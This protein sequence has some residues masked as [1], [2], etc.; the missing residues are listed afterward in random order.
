[1]NK[2]TITLFSVFIAVMCIA[3]RTVTLIY[4]T[5]SATGFFISKLSTLGILISVA[6]FVFALIASFFAFTVSSSELK[7]LEISKTNGIISIL[8]GVS[9]ILYCFG[10]GIHDTVFLW[11]R[12]LETVSG[13]AAGLWFV[14]FGV[15]AFYS[16]KMPEYLSAIP[17]I[18][19]IFRL[20]VVFGT[21]SSNA[22]VAEHIFSLAA[23]SSTCVFMLLFGKRYVKFESEKSD[24]LFYP[25]AICA[26]ILNLTSSLSRII[27]TVIGASDRIHAEANIDLVSL[28]AG[29]F[30]LVMVTDIKSKEKE[31]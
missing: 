12:I 30:M 3:A 31:S 11:Q 14:I 19:W 17:C 22:L 2:K 20:I 8:L 26:A 23:L 21:F 27:V 9:I 29:V 13:F 16:I 18:H 4:A 10:F 15:N 24:K 25:T 1:M 5:E 28:F 6:I 7:S